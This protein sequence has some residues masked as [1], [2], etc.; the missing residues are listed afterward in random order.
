MASTPITELGGNWDVDKKFFAV[1]ETDILLTNSGSYPVRF[2]I[3]DSDI[4]PQLNVDLGHFLHPGES[5]A[6]SLLAGER[7]WVAAPGAASV[8]ASVTIGS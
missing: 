5:R 2:E 7:L 8:S 1:D 3:T 4:P 6:M